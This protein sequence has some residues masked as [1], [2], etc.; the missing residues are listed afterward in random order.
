MRLGTIAAAAVAL[1]LVSGCERAPW[2][3][4]PDVTWITTY[5]DDGSEVGEDALLA[6]DGGYFITGAS[7]L[8]FGP[9]PQGD[10]YLIRT[11]SARR[12]LW[13]MTY[14]GEGLEIGTSIIRVSDGT[15]AIGG[16]ASSLDGQG[17]DAYLMKV[18]LEGNELWSA[19]FGGPLDERASVVLE[20]PDNGYLLV[21]NVVDPADAVSNPGAAGYTGFD[22]RSSVYLVR[23]DGDGNELWSRVHD[24]GANVLARSGIRMP[25]GDFLLL[26]TI[27][28]FPDPDDD[29]YL[30]R[31]NP[32]GDEVWSRTWKD[33]RASGFDLIHTSDGNYIIAG[34]YASSDDTDRSTADF[35]FIKVD[36][37][38]KEMWSRTH[39]DPGMIDYADAIT[40]TAD[41]CYV[42][43]GD[44]TKSFFTR[45]EDLV[46]VK[47]D[48]SGALLW[49]R[50]FET[51][52]HNMLGTVLQHPAG[53]YAVAGSTIMEDE[54]F[55]I[56]LITTDSEGKVE[57]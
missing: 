11:D 10:L 31:V 4:D 23:T 32:N 8:R 37:E 28:Y 38:G 47:I 17:I 54:A 6:A 24:N 41:G 14:G 55:D 50:T 34:S 46:L 52:T 29:L 30:V 13:E 19:R 18:D 56:F 35:L 27:T 1:I 5:G 15:L 48:E 2:W 49:E 42:A 40:E 53:G 57:R 33:G 21:G 12:I 16:Q 36:P 25:G 39:G 9:E 22:G 51:A 45:S 20:T 43:A 44:R 26:A 3:T 7:N